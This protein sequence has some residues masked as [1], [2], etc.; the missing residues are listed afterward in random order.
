M[1]A[2]AAVVLLLVATAINMIRWSILVVKIQ[3]YSMF[4]LVGRYGKKKLTS[5]ERDRRDRQTSLALID[6]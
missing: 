4:V 5:W 6:P 1:A 2:V 3:F